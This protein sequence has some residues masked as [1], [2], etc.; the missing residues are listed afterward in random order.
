MKQKTCKYC[1]EKFTP[2]QPLQYLCKPPKDCSWK[3]IQAQAVKKREK[4]NREWKKTEKEKQMTVSDYKALFQVEI[5]LIAR[6]IDLNQPCIASQATK[7]KWNG[8]HYISVKANE[9]IRF[10]LH[11]IHIQV[12]ESNH[13]KSGDTIKYQDGLKRVYGSDYFEFVERLRQTQPIKLTIETLKEKISI[14]KLIVKELKELGNTYTAK[15]RTD[16]R[17]E[18]NLR[19]GIYFEAYQYPF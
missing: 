4:D 14:A 18:Y 13:F 6:L 17:N 2:E 7:G 8:G 16:L 9:T 12:F 15:E 5:N 1:K 11:N 19:L 10:N 3:Y